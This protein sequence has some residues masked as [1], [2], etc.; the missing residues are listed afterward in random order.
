MK[1]GFTLIELLAVFIILGVT[2]TLVIIKIDNNIKNANDFAN[3]QTIGLIENAAYLYEEEYRSELLN[4][5]SLKV[6]TVTIS[7]LI[8]KG[9]INSNDIKNIPTS[10]IVLIAEISKTIKTKYT[11]TSKNV[12]FLN[13]S[14]EISISQN[15]QYEELGAYVAIPG[16]GVIELDESNISSNIDIYTKGKYEVIYSYPNTTSVK[17]IVNVI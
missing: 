13:G 4:I 11:I 6:D 2:M 15:N 14:E 8:S 17:R 9:L 10:N 5:D 3:E 12:I 1:R 7:T 16:T